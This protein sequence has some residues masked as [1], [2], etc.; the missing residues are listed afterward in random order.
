MV[1]RKRRSA[2]KKKLSTRFKQN[3]VG[4]TKSEFK[5]LGLLGQVAVVGIG[6]GAL[7]VG[8]AKKL[9]DLPVVGQI[10]SI[11]TGIGK[12]L[13]GNGMKKRYR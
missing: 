3:P 1:A 2:P 6:A 10:F 12:S 11:F 13:K 9:D 5:K 7:S 8:V 4:T